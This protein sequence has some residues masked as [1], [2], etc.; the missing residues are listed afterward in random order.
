MEVLYEIFQII[1]CYNDDGTIYFRNIA[2]PRIDI[3]Y[4]SGNTKAR[5]FTH[6]TNVYVLAD[7]LEYSGGV[8]DYDA[9]SLIAR[10]DDDDSYFDK[11]RIVSG[12]VQAT[13]DTINLDEPYAE[14]GSDNLLR[15]LGEDW[16]V[17]YES[18][19]YESAVLEAY[20][21]RVRLSRIDGTMVIAAPARWSDIPMPG[22]AI[23]AGEYG[24]WWVYATRIDSGN[25]TISL[26]VRQVQPPPLM[27]QFAAPR[28]IMW[29]IQF[30]NSSKRI[31][32]S[33][34][35]SGTETAFLGMSSWEESPPVRTIETRRY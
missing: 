6:P 22:D 31:Y 12:R 33:P 18:G 8:I 26:D 25:Q 16:T 11:R 3:P 21:Q 29:Y 15:I 7:S 2:D 23:D 14:D 5:T 27:P 32:L 34:D 30:K 19:D 35:P 17:K 13:V 9:K 10:I 4:G 20:L 24:D 28:G 1:T